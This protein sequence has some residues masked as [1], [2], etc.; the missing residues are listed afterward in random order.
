[1]AI[2]IKEISEKLNL[3]R[4]T[5][6][7]ALNNKQVLNSRGVPYISA[8]TIDRVLK[9]SKEM[10]Y[11]PNRIARSLALGKSMQIAF[12]VPDMKAR[13]FQEFSCKLHDY[14]RTVE[15]EMILCEFAEHMMSQTSSRS[16]VRADVDGVILYGGD[17][18]DEEEWKSF[19]SQLAIVNMGIV[20]YAG[21]LDYLQI[22]SY[23]AVVE[24]LEHL[25]KTNRNKIINVLWDDMKWDG[26]PR[27]SAYLKTLKKAGKTPEFLDLEVNPDLPHKE[28]ARKSA[29]RY[30]KANGCPDAFFCAED[31]IAIGVYKGIRDMGFKIP[32]DVAIIG[33]NGIPETEYFDPSISTI[34]HPIDEMCAQAWK[35]LSKRMEKSDLPRQEHSIKAKFI[36]RGSSQGR[37]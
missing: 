37:N 15:Y 12:W 28:S 3:S 17:I 11:R 21:P 33:F 16:V 36:S 22:D 7:R 4:S 18:G 27:Y 10:G 8:K 29:C 23:P 34:T 31:E 9:A 1:M 32:E 20:Q 19:A 5:V 13:S 30:I 24:A 25:I 26:D 35:L 14:L 6:S 2:G